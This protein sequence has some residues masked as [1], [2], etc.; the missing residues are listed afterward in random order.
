MLPVVSDLEWISLAVG[1]FTHELPPQQGDPHRYR[2][3]HHLRFVLEPVSVILDLDVM[4]LV[5]KR[6]VLSWL[7]QG[8]QV[9]KALDGVRSLFEAKNPRPEPSRCGVLQAV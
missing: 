9:S 7:V 5:V 8:L 1:P 6:L 2:L 3:I 4:E